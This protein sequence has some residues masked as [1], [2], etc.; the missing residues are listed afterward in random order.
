[1]EANIVVVLLLYWMEAD[2]SELV[3]P[4]AGDPQSVKVGCSRSKVTISEYV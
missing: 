4:T 2:K 1:M 3:A